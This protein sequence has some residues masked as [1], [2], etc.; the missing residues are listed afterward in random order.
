MLPP[1]SQQL[2]SNGQGGMPRKTPV[3][4]S[5]SVPPSTLAQATIQKYNLVHA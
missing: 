2:F 4:T 1:E 3:F 5:A